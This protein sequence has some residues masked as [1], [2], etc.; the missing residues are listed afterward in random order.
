MHFLLPL[1]LLFF[2]GFASSADFD[3]TDPNQVIHFVSVNTF[4]RIQA[5]ADRLQADPA[6]MQVVIEE[7][8]LPYFDYKYASYKVLGTHLKQTTKEQR[9]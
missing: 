6:Y 2:S 3:K 7:E 8:L 9:D 4:A 1:L 5:D